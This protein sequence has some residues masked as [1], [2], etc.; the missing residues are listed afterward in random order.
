MKLLLWTI[1][2]SGKHTVNHFGKSYKNCIEIGGITTDTHSGR[3][4]IMNYIK[5]INIRSNQSQTDS[6][7]GGLMIWFLQQMQ[8]E[9]N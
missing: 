5:L 9:H 3:L 2:Y 8:Q 6:T 4:Q 1:R 7:D